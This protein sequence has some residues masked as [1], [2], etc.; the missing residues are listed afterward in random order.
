MR[1]AAS[2]Q[3]HVAVAPQCGRRLAS[4]RGAAAPRSWAEGGNRARAAPHGLPTMSNGYRTLSQHLNDL[5]KEN[6]SLKLRIYFLEERMQ[7]KYEASREDI[8]KRVSAVGG[9]HSAGAAGG[10]CGHIKMPGCSYVPPHA[11]RTSEGGGSGRLW[12]PSCFLTLDKPI[13]PLLFP[14]LLLCKNREWD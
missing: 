7:Q 1:E 12:S 6:F 10:Q 3:G 8:Y 5:K 2:R 13:S 11:V 14:T 9:C 4:C